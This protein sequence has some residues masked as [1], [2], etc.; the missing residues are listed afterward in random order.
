MSGLFLSVILVVSLVIGV[1]AGSPEVNKLLKA[2]IHLSEVYNVLFRSP[3][4]GSPDHDDR[5]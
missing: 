1:Y 4:D 3:D 2:K 5:F